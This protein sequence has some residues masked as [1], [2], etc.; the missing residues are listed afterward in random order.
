[1]TSFALTLLTVAAVAF[2]VIVAVRVCTAWFARSARDREAIRGAGLR[3]I[4]WSVARSTARDWRDGARAGIRSAAGWARARRQAAA[5]AASPPPAAPPPPRRRAAPAPGAPAAPSDPVTAPGAPPAPVP[6]DWGQVAARI[7]DYEPEDDADFIAHMRGE[8]S[9][10]L[11]VAEAIHARGETLMT[12]VRLDPSIVH[13][14][15]SLADLVGECASGASG[16]HG[17]LLATY[18]G[19]KQAI[20]A[21]LILPHDGNFLTAAED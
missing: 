18:G 4:A 11:A 12:T 1:M 13:A 7:A 20:A 10:L 9:G 19:I 3:V 5:P 14:N 8:A 2:A 15:L 17:M 6:V 21:G 16:V